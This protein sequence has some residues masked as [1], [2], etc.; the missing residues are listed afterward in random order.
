MGDPILTMGGIGLLKCGL[1]SYFGGS[2][3]TGIPQIIHNLNQLDH[4]FI[5]THG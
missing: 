3:V 1:L 4:F 5:E 2:R